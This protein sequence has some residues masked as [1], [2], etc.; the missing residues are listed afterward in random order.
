MARYRDASVP[1]VPPRGHEALPQGRALLHRQVRDRAPELPARP[2]RPAARQARRRTACSCARSRRP[3][4]S[5]ACSRRSSAGTSSGPSARRASP[6][7]TC[8]GCSSGAWTTWCTAWASPPP[9]REARQ[10]VAHGHFQ[11]NGRKVVVP[12]F[13]VKVGEVVQLR[14]DLQAAGARRRQ[15]RPRAGGQ[16]PQWLDAGRER[17]RRA[18]CAGLPLREDIQIPVQE[19]LIVELYSQVRSAGRRGMA[20]IPFQKP[21]TI[22]WE[23]LIATATA[24]W[25]PSRSRR[26]TR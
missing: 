26:A 22:E 7:R 14:A 20:R 9:A 25:W 18:T 16:I 3:S 5:T 12:S 2:A 4:A 21:K 10:M 8:C 23:I 11:V 1:A 15:R 6:A 17:A 24:G 19:Q 13:L